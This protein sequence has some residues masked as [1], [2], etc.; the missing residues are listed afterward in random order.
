MS[1]C[2]CG[3]R[4]LLGRQLC[5]R[6]R[7]KALQRKCPC[8]VVI[9]GAG[10]SYCHVCSVRRREAWLKERRRKDRERKQDISPARIEEIY[11]AVIA[12]QRYERRGQS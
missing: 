6:C 1:Q 9:T 5:T 12:R 11:Q 10:R 8:G 7:A 4:T 2:A 3:A